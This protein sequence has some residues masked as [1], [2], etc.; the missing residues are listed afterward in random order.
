MLAAFDPAVPAP[1]TQTA[2]GLDLPSV[3]TSEFGSV[4]TSSFESMSVMLLEEHWGIHGGT[5]YD[6]CTQE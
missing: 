3:F 2:T 5:A 6:T 1:F 4:T